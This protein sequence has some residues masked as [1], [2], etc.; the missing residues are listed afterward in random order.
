LEVSRI[1]FAKTTSR[2]EPSLAW[3]VSWVDAQA[4]AF[5]SRT[6][7]PG[8]PRFETWD[9]PVFLVPKKADLAHRKE[10][11]KDSA[12]CSLQPVGVK[13]GVRGPNALDQTW[14]FW[15]GGCTE[16]QGTRYR[17]EP[18]AVASMAQL[19]SGA[20]PYGHVCVVCVTVPPQA[21]S[22]GRPVSQTRQVNK[23]ER[24]GPEK[25]C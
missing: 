4:F 15:S 6:G 19:S 18:R 13:L 25:P 9:M 12:Q 22:G 1:F 7:G 8:L 16:R 14:K 5:R 11:P 2:E 24:D 20:H 23:L 3:G 17:C 21:G 10:T